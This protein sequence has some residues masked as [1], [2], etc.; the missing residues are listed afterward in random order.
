MSKGNAQCII[1]QIFCNVLCI[2]FYLWLMNE[3]TIGDQ[4]VEWR[5]KRDLR[6]VDLAKKLG[7]KSQNLRNYESGVRQVSYLTLK[8]ICDALDVDIVFQ[9]KQSPPSP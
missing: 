1:K 8:A 2:I 7:I 6:Q 4:I 5:I 3:K 9:D